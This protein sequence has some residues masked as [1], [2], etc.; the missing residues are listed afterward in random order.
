MSLQRETEATQQRTDSL[1]DHL[2]SPTSGTREAAY[3]EPEDMFEGEAYVPVERPRS[4]PPKLP[5]LHLEGGDGHG[6]F[7]DGGAED[8]FSKIGKD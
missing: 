1:D 4:P 8:L 3:E 7:L 6:G 5:E 2:A